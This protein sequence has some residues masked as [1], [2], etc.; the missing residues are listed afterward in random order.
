MVNIMTPIAEFMVE[1]PFQNG[2]AAPAFQFYET[3]AGEE[4]D[5]VDEAAKELHEA[6][7]RHL[8]GAIDAVQGDLK[9]KALKAIESSAKCISWPV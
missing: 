1:E 3:K 4:P 9:K 6:I 7:K 5:D 2:S 8:G